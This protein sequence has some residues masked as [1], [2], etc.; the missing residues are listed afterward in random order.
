MWAE[1]RFSAGVVGITPP[2]ARAGARQ[3]LRVQARA[4]GGVIPTTPAEN[5]VSAHIG[6]G[7]RHGRAS[8]AFQRNQ[9]DHLT[10]DTGGGG[11]ALYRHRDLAVD[12]RANG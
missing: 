8:D 10:V 4:V 1:T 3:E 5:R 2:T 12:V 6:R 7:H 9:G 11:K